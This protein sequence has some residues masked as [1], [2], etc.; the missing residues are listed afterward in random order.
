MAKPYYEF[1]C[2]VKVIAGHA[3]LEH[4]PFEL[5][6]LGAARPLII[7]DKGVRSNNLLAPIEAAFESTDAVIGCIFD[8]VPPDSS[9]ETVRKAAQLYRE[10]NCDAIIAVGGGSVI[11]TS[12]ATNI[13]V[14][15][16]GDDLLK[17]SGAHNL[18]RPLKPFFVIPTTSGTGSEVTMVAV[19]SDNQKNVKMPFA[20]YYL[21]PHAAILDP[22]MTQTLP[23][24]LTAMT[25]MDAMTH[26]V[27]AYTCLAANPISDAYATAAIKKISANLFN[28]LDNPTEANGRLELAQASTMAGIAFSNSMV[29]LVHS[30]GH[31]LGAVAHLPHGLCMNLFLPYVLEY[32]K[33]INADKLADLLLPLA[34]PD[35][36]AQ[37]PAHLRADKTISTLQT[38]RDRIYALTKLPRTLRETGKV[39]EAQ[40]DEIAEKALNDGS[41]IY[42]P[43]EA[44]L[45]DLKTILEKAW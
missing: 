36:Y 29:G 15:E 43:K 33:E 5:A 22:R 27:E 30:L 16:G 41:I 3:A 39:S 19:V 7:T 35:I 38:M 1:F 45:Q 24:H 9:L 42:N 40:F 6:A 20:S 8:D 14:S 13:L 17:Y 18:P 37:T 12:K 26:A 10:N 23:P 31:S 34:G 21:M 32:N 4:I 25:A 44:T 28:V 2:P 11:D